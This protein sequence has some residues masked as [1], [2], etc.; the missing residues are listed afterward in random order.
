[1]SRSSVPPAAACL[2][3]AL[4]SVGSPLAAVKCLLCPESVWR[5][6]LIRTEN[7]AWP[8]RALISLWRGHG[9]PQPQPPFLEVDAGSWSGRLDGVEAFRG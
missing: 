1:M 6:E 5:N 3:P 8:A 4:A 2:R 9:G 7:Q